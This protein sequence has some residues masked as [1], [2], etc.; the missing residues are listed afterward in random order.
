MFFL[1]YKDGRGSLGIYITQQASKGLLD[2]SANS[3]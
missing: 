2:T 1:F 3:A